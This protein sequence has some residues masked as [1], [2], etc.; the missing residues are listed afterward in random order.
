MNKPYLT[1][2]QRRILRAKQ[3]ELQRRIY[4]KLKEQ[5]QPSCK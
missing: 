5:Q 1:D 4:A 3:L 2:K